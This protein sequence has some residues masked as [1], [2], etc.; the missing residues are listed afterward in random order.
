M[1]RVMSSDR[2]GR[3][4]RDVTGTALVACLTVMGLVVTAVPAQA[5]GDPTD[6]IAGVVESAVATVPQVTLVEGAPD[7]EVLVP[8]DA[9]GEVDVRVSDEVGFAVGL[10]AEADTAA[11]VIADN[12]ST[13]YLGVGDSADVSV[14]TFDHG[15]RISTV[16]AASD[17]DSVFT[18]PL[19]EGVTSELNAD[20][21]V[22]LFKEV[23]AA[24]PETGETVVAQI[25]IAVVETPWAVDASGTTIPT[26]YELTDDAIVQVVDRSGDIDYPVVAD[27]TFTQIN[28]FQMRIRWNRAETATIA[29]GGWGATGITA[30]CGLAGAAAGGPIGAAAFA[31]LC[32][33]ASASAVY[34]AGVA[35]NSNPKR[36]LQLTVTFTIITSPI[37][38]FDTY[39]G[40]Y[41]S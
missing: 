12:G 10:P 30:V 23:E 6:S 4:R 2:A 29:A 37:P 28:P 33:A 1:K 31:A 27:P 16:I 25:E 3:T 38:Y 5:A 32:F 41:C 40:G 20:Q 39:S 13:V 22:S 21:T 24:D 9:S 34:T 11:G 18:Y 15:V 26:H 35:Q 8:V 14:E 36:C 7:I 17:T 19:E